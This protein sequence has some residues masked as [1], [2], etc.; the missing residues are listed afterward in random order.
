[1]VGGSK[2]IY[3]NM[4]TNVYDCL[5]S[6]PG[7]SKAATSLVASEIGDIIDVAVKEH[8]E[9]N[10]GPGVKEACEEFASGHKLSNFCHEEL[11]YVAPTTLVLTAG[12]GECAGTYQYVDLKKQ[13][14][15]L[16]KNGRLEGC[17][18]HSAIKLVIYFDEFGICNPLRNKATDYM[19]GAVY[20]A[21]DEGL[22][23]SALSDIY[24]V[25][26][27]PVK[28]MKLHG[29]QTVIKPAIKSL[30]DLL[31][32]G[33]EACNAHFSVTLE[34]VAGD[35]LGVHKMA[36]FQ[37]SFSC[38]C[39]PC[40]TCY[41]TNDQFMTKLTEDELC[42]RTEEQY[43]EELKML[44]E[45]AGD[46]VRKATGINSKCVFDGLSDFKVTEKFPPDIAHDL[47]E[48]GVVTH[49]LALVLTYLIFQMK[50]FSMGTFQRAMTSFTYA[51]SDRVN[52][53][54]VLQARGRKVL[55]KGTFSQCWTLLR[56]LPFMIG[57]LVP[58][59]EDVWV[60]LVDLL[61]LV[62]IL[63][64]PRMDDAMLD[65]M[66]PLIE[67]WLK[68]F[69]R[70]FPDFHLTPKF[71]YLLHYRHW[72]TKL[73][74][75]RKSWTMRFEAKH[76]EFKVAATRAHNIKNVSKTLAVRHQERIASCARD[77]K[78]KISSGRK[79]TPRQVNAALGWDLAVDELSYSKMA[80][81][82]GQRYCADDVLVLRNPA[83]PLVGDMLLQVAFFQFDATM[84]VSI[85]G[86]VMKV[87][88]FDTHYMAYIVTNS[89]Q[90][91]LLP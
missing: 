49:T 61:L 60:L 21:V 14:K 19:L 37:E 13:L 46:D 77:M 59:N 29:M 86:N 15:S 66:K 42:L 7:L 40:R 8:I 27:C 73:G 64:A 75:L 38:G 1:M 72:A 39:R 51:R 31:K 71:H 16:L 80:V 76:Q 83:N 34:F 84:H 50:L 45:D 28:L 2:W 5:Q 12:R 58:R 67:K 32:N 20:F 81:L 3:F 90:L 91:M 62:Q 35:N 54:R 26:L 53:P 33:L 6:E 57:S 48:S 52:T 74:S 89:E 25:L 70:N 11:C 85:I 18:K 44:E 88:S 56:V 30:D 17:K 79:C 10:D 78:A 4:V 43:Q 23:M 82:H 9:S 69:C 63:C 41:A 47:F 55:V 22:S 36:G 24:L 87:Q 65:R 68:D